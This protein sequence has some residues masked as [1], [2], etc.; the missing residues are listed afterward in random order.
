M[1]AAKTTVQAFE[2]YWDWTEEE[3]EA[4]LKEAGSRTFASPERE[5][6]SRT[7]RP[8]CDEYVYE[9]NGWKYL[10]SA[11]WSRDGGGQEIVYF[12]GQPVWVMNYYGFLADGAD[13][14][15]VYGFLK[16]TLRHKHRAL[17]AK[18]TAEADAR[19]G[20][21]YEIEFGRKDIGNFQGIERIR[22]G[23]RVV[24]ECYLHGGFVD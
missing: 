24:Y 18:N 12:R 22:K 16:E 8:G 5:K 15:L 17:R 6:L 20:L 9:A 19:T 2:R 13:R 11:A 10:D 21:Q 4:F 14:D 1:Q 23:R 3:L 7:H